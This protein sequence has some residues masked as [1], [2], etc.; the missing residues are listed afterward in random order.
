MLKTSLFLK[1]V[2]SYPNNTQILLRLRA[3]QRRDGAHRPADGESRAGAARAVGRARDQYQASWRSRSKHGRRAGRE[4]AVAHRGVTIR[5]GG[6]ACVHL[7]VLCSRTKLSPQEKIRFSCVPRLTPHRQVDDRCELEQQRASS[8]RHSAPRAHSGG[9]EQRHD[10]FP[11]ASHR[12]S[13]EN[14]AQ[15]RQ[16]RSHAPPQPAVVF[17]DVDAA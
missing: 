16:G 4:E 8:A 17:G 12:A 5:D 6:A 7:F 15:K 2:Y 3:A 9:H 13:A 11:P 1:L 14:T 10:V